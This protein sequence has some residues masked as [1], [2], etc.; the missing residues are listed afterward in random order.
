MC[1]L[2]YCDIDT[3][4]SK[5]D[6]LTIKEKLFAAKSRLDN[7]HHVDLITRALDPFRREKYQIAKSIGEKHVSNAWLK[8][9]D[10]IMKFKLLSGK[11]V[12]RHYDGA[13]LPGAFILATQ[14]A[15]R[16]YINGCDYKWRACSLYDS[17][18]PHLGDDYGLLRQ[19]PNNWLMDEKNNGDITNIDNINNITVKLLNK[20]NFYTSD[21]GFDVSTDYNNQETLHFCANTG[22]ILLCLK[23]LQVG[24]ICVIKHYT[25]LEEYTLKYL[26]KFSKLFKYFYLYKPVASKLLNSE[27]YLVG[28]GFIGNRT[29][30]AEDLERC[31]VNKS[32]S[33]DYEFPLSFIDLI[34][35]QLKSSVNNQVWWLDKVVQIAQT[36]GFSN[37]ENNSCIDMK[38]INEEVRR[39]KSVPVIEYNSG[40]LFKLGLIA[41]AQ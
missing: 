1:A 9:F 33:L 28:I 31:L 25:Y 37:N 8:C 13:S 27:V 21:L 23:V 41:S 3:E 34:W 17:D 38:K 39:Y 35:P 2:N 30:M 29:T 12:I 10:I 32:Y 15:V 5:A 22:Q 7:I 18:I 26:S 24:G 16:H 20:T 6:I 40:R 14:Y 4:K 19:F 36:V 11:T